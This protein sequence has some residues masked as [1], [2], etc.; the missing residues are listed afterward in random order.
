MTPDNSHVVPL[1][2]ADLHTLP[3][4]SDELRGLLEKAKN[5]PPMTPAQLFEQKVSWCYGQLGHNNPL[6]KEQVRAMIL[7]HEGYI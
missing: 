4:M 6:T 7:R 2:P 1:I 3:A 5:M